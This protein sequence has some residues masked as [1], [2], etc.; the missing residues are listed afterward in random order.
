MAELKALFSV[1]PLLMNSKKKYI[2]GTDHGAMKLLANMSSSRIYVEG[3]V[4]D[5]SGVVGTT[6]FHKPIFDIESI[7]GQPDSVIYAT[8]P[9][10]KNHDDSIVY[11]EDALVLPKELETSD[12][13]IYGAGEIG[14]EI[15]QYVMEKTGRPIY[16]FIDSDRRKAGTV[17]NGILVKGV[18]EIKNISKDA[19]IIEA[20]RCW[21]E[22]EDMICQIRTDIK[23]FYCPLFLQE[24]FER[25][26]MDDK[27]KAVM[28]IDTFAYSENTLDTKYIFYDFATLD[29]A[30]HAIDIF[31]L[32]DYHN[33]LIA[34]DN[35]SDNNNYA[36]IPIINIVDV[37]YLENCSIIMQTTRKTAVEKLEKLGLTEGIIMDAG[38]RLCLVKRL[39]EPDGNL[40]YGYKMNTEYL[41]V[42]M[43]GNNHSSDYKIVILGGSTSDSGLSTFPSWAELLY[44]K[45]RDKDVTIYNCANS[46]YTSTQELIKL[47]RDALFFKPNL[48]ISYSGVNDIFRGFQRPITSPFHFPGVKN[49]SGTFLEVENDKSEF[50]IWMLNMEYMHA[51]AELNNS[52]FISFLQPILGSKKQYTKKE[53]IMLREFDAVHLNIFSHKSREFRDNAK[54]FKDIPYIYDFSD[55][56]DNVEVYYDECHVYEEGNQ[57]IADKIYEILNETVFKL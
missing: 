10:I 38:A 57:I 6:F 14:R 29:L 50:E 21:A 53:Q 11:V 33:L 22:M 47:L 19:V 34:V 35:E 36:G 24:I 56:F 43:Y 54:A 25:I 31:S 52:S 9:A 32:F 17:V 26:I 3:F 5:D 44:R 55:I 51:I 20:G 1:N 39:G 18:E 40:G 2:Y 49:V 23:R 41:G 30:K 27:N 28:W 7:K 37:L 8:N 46:G 48:I 42:H 16:C 15:A 4:S 12:I 45:F 13:V